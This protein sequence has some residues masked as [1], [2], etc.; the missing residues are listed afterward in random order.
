MSKV[1]KQLGVEM[2]LEKIFVIP[3]KRTRY[4]SEISETS[5][6]NLNESHAQ[7]PKNLLF[8]FIDQKH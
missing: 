4:L 8:V 3:P 6:S 5:K 7:T 1:E 2:F